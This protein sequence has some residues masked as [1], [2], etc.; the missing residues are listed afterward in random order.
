MRHVSR[1]PV[2]G[3]LGALVTLALV[4][5]G[6]VP[7]T[8]TV[9]AG[10][11]VAAL[12]HWRYDGRRDYR[13]AGTVYALGAAG[14][15][16]TL[17]SASPVTTWS[18]VPSLVVFG[19]ASALVTGAFVL[20]RVG[21]RAVARRFVP[22]TYAEALGDFA[23]T[24]ASAAVVIWTVIQ[25]QER[26][27]RTAG[28]GF[29]GTAALAADWYGLR[30][31]VDL[32]MIEGAIQTTVVVFVGA[33]VVGFHTLASWDSAWRVAEESAARMNERRSEAPAAAAEE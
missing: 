10:A 6:S 16:V 29:L 5:V 4:L 33:V 31:S 13:V 26:L 23:S 1:G 3:A 27:A 17:P 28:T 24:L 25:V 8:G 12:L 11:L 14:G 2:A 18:L 19:L 20:V 15:L 30:Y 22:E 21:V 9:F 32:A 7:P